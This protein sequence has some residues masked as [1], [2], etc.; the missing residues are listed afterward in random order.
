MD[1]LNTCYPKKEGGT[2]HFDDILLVLNRH[3]CI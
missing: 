1:W 3:K 2:R